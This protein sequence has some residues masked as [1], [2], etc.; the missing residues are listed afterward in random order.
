MKRFSYRN[1]RQLKLLVICIILFA[2]LVNC[3][4]KAIL[5]KEE[6]A[7]FTRVALGPGDEIEIKFFNVPE[8]N[9]I[10]TVRHDGN[11]SLHL[12]GDVYVE[13]MTASELKDTLETLYKDHLQTPEILVIPRT[14][15]SGVVHVG[16]EVNRPGNIDMPGRFT[17]L[18][19]IMQAGGFNFS[20]ASVDDVRI[21]RLK[22]GNYYMAKLDLKAALKGK[23]VDP[24]YLEPH[25][26][27]FVPQ[28]R[29]T[30]VA[31]WFNRNI[32][33]LLPPGFTYLIPYI[34]FER[35]R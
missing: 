13:D 20:T 2:F 8:L 33:S 17:A 34:I 6:I 16:G 25:D 11:I 27:V 32:Y 21:L 23:D 29:I 7:T 5:K 3:S 22:S 24:F 14:L 15:F 9:E 12:V 19:A 4:N 30:K 10:Q 18:E 26:I 35:G 1:S 31:Q 28:T